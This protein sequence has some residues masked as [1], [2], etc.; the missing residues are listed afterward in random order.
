MAEVDPG[1][2]D[3][4]INA[5]PLE[6]RGG[7]GRTCRTGLGGG[8]PWMG[9]GGGVGWEE[10]WRAFN[11]LKMCISDF[12]EMIRFWNGFGRNSTLFP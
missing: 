3:G 6:P 11:D 2:L 12:I 1:T 7:M 8:W 4:I 5:P 9:W 10:G